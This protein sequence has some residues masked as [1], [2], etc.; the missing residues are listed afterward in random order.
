MY[1]CPQNADQVP[2]IGISAIL[3]L[4]VSLPVTSRGKSG[5]PWILR[6]NRALRSI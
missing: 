2:V 5:M 4:T 1:T 3:L 6:R